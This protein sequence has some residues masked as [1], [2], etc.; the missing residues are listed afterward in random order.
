MLYT[1]S[2]LLARYRD[3][4]A[5][6]WP[7]GLGRAQH[8]PGSD[9]GGVRPPVG[10][11]G[12]QPGGPEPDPGGD[13][14]GEPNPAELPSGQQTGRLLASGQWPDSEVQR[15]TAWSG[16]WGAYPWT[17]TLPI[18]AACEDRDGNL[19]VG[20]YG[21]GV[22]WFDAEGKATRISKEEGLSHNSVLSL[23]V[24]R[25]GCLWVGTNGGGLNRVRRRLFDVLERSR[26]FGGAIGLRGRPGGAVDRIHRQPGG[27]LDTGPARSSS[28]SSP[29]PCR[30]M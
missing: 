20:T 8:V 3:G 12:Y 19:V 23:T 28:A 9:C 27:P 26:G 16:I 10:R 4:K 13:G 30:W 18:V 25:E 17:N 15:E 21:D 6:V 5:E 24:D 7:A 1:D 29:A 14:R 22:Y 11:H 2:G